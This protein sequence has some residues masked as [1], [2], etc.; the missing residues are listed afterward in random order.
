MRPYFSLLTVC[1]LTFLAACEGPAGPAGADGA[2]GADGMEGAMGPAGPTGAAGDDGADGAD[3]AEGP[4]GQPGTTGLS[5]SMWWI[6]N[7]GADN[8]GTVTLRN[9]VWSSLH[10]T[11]TESNEGVFFDASNNLVHAGDASGAVG[12]RTM[13]TTPVGAAAF[14]DGRDRLLAGST[15]GMTN[16]KGLV[17]SHRHGVYFVADTGAS[18]LH[19][20]GA[21]AAGDA[22]P[23]FSLALTASAWDLAYDEASDRAYLALTNGTVGVIDNLM[24]RRGEASIDRIITPSSNG[25]SIGVNLHGIA[26]DADH[27]ALVVT[28]VGAANAAA[29]A[30]FASDGAI[31]VLEN[32]STASGSVM[33][34][35]E[36]R[37]PNSALG[38]PV[39]LVMDGDDARVAEKAQGK[40]LVFRDVFS[41]MS[42]DA[43][44]EVSVDT[45]APESLARQPD[46]L[47]TTNASD[48]IDPTTGTRGVYITS[49]PA[50]AGDSSDEGQIWLASRT[51]LSA[52]MGFQVIDNSLDT[53]DDIGLTSAE[54][55]TLG[56]DG[57]A[58]MTFDAPSGG[59]GV[60]VIGSIGHR[61][62]GTYT[63]KWDRT[64]A[65]ANTGIINPKGLEV[66]D[67][68]GLLLVAD[69]GTDGATASVRVFG[70][71]ASGD[72]APLAVVDTDGARPWDLHHD[73]WTDTLW[74]ANTNGTVGVYDHFSQTLG[75][76]GPSRVITP[77]DDGEQISVNLHSVRYDVVTDSL[78]LADVGAAGSDTDGQLFVIP[79]A[80]WADGETQVERIVGGFGSG[81]GNPVDIAFDG[82]DL[83]VAEKANNAV[84]L[85]RDFLYA[86]VGDSIFDTLEPDVVL[87][88]TA[89]ESVVIAPL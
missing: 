37:G 80:G 78:I 27:D 36:I 57:T 71:C 49:N 11:T 76:N 68:L 60:A 38:N 18:A 45:Q 7:N 73:L 65:G 86:P 25:V 82:R 84:F 43:F 35:R 17:V 9:E 58:Y 62:M 74:L 56:S 39:D 81:L 83:Y 52:Q 47:M 3:G 20:F 5:P 44:P 69:I 31:Y 72:V 21:Q 53:D 34:M 75:A 22:A 6:S 59:S 19:V 14:T 13:C 48:I 2:D 55:I 50:D 12:I 66:V 64:I 54:N 46:P 24:D 33:P 61:S 23:L 16:P 88:A 67:E 70:S 1:A 40:L 77:F 42:G 28:D 30:D 51:L 4:Q 10:T 26:Y 85:Y 79:F 8:R 15:T 89:P 29:S 63:S 41:G 87:D 32:A